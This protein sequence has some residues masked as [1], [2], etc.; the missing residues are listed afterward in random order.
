MDVVLNVECELDKWNK[1]YVPKW[2]K[3]IL[4]SQMNHEPA[5]EILSFVY[6]PAKTT[7]FVFVQKFSL[8]NTS[9]IDFRKYIRKELLE[10][11]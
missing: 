6:L 11:K 8:M 7:K 10:A 5:G 2:I 4:S 3:Q 1:S 9:E